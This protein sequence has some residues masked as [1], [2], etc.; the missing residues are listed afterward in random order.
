MN[1]VDIAIVYIVMFI[2]V[3]ALAASVNHGE[4]IN[5]AIDPAIS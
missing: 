4:S 2:I 3:Y 5:S 1:I